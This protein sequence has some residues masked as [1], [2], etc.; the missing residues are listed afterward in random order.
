MMHMNAY[1]KLYRFNAG[2]E[3]IWNAVL[4]MFARNSC[5]KQSISSPKSVLKKISALICMAFIVMPQSLMAEITSSAANLGGSQQTTTSRQVFNPLS[6]PDYP[7]VQDSYFTDDYGNI[8]MIVNIIGEVGKSGQY[9]VRENADFSTILAIAGGLKPD[10]N[11]GKVVVAHQ[12]P[13]DNGKQANVINL[14]SYYK[15][16][17]RTAFIALKPNDTIIIPEKGI[18][19]NKVAKVMSIAY[20][21]IN[22]YDIVD[23]RGN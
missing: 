3:A 6:G 8:L 18:S 13:D 10:A 17:D 7:M 20:P 16:G 19:L 1:Y 14:K 12:Q 21:F 15:H 5:R 11:L 22:I 4:G 2:R 23:S 9:V